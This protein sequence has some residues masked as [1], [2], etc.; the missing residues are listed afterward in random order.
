MTGSAPNVAL[1][2]TISSRLTE[3][4]QSASPPATAP[5]ARDAPGAV[6]HVSHWLASPDGRLMRARSRNGRAR[7]L[8]HSPRLDILTFAYT[9]NPT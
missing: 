4:F 7:H 1:A 6:P 2:R 8:T 9:H 5:E 3:F